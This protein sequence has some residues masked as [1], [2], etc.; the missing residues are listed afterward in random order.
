MATLA[1]Y[2]SWNNSFSHFYS[3][4]ASPLYCLAKEEACNLSLVS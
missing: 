2:N 1:K 4:K 3:K